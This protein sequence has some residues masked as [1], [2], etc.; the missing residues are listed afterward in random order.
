[1]KISIGINLTDGPWGGGNQFG[2]TIS[3]YLVKTGSQVR[4]DLADDDIDVI[5]LT[6]PRSTVSASAFNDIHIKDYLTFKNSS[7]IVVHRINECDQRK[8]TT[9]V[10]RAIINANSCADF[11]VFISEYLRDVFLEEGLSTEKLM[12]IRNGA[13]ESIFYPLTETRYWNDRARIVTHHWGGHWLKGFDIYEKLDECL[14]IEDWNS[15]FEFTYIGGL[16]RNFSFKNS[17]YIKPLSGTQLGDELRRHDIYLTASR[18][19][20]AGMHHV[21][22]ASCG[23]PLLFIDSGALPEY[24][25]GFGVCFQEHNFEDKLL[26]I[27]SSREHWVK[28]LRSYPYR[29]QLMCESYSQL[30]QAL[31]DDRKNILRSRK[32]QYRKNIFG[33]LGYNYRNARQTVISKMRTRWGD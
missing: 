33:R 20:P 5:L 12:V 17:R 9:G 16:P 22:A 10:N 27:S 23:L 6:D 11:T 21:E 26:E 8:G 19:E 13:D 31:I 3:K 4:F 30:F 29:S 2:N 28:Q 15:K 1:M 32:L 7:A 24:C 25:E 18:N 14:S